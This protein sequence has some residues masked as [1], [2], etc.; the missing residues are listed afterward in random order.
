M[1]V[2]GLRILIRGRSLLGRLSRFRVDR[3]AL[4]W[5]ANRRLRDQS[6]E[7]RVLRPNT[8]IEGHKFLSR[9]FQHSDVTD[10][11]CYHMLDAIPRDAQDIA[12][13]GLCRRASPAF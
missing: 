1:A 8:S 5:T 3:S 7:P 9:G 2:I 13:L 11:H 12:F 4:L 10:R 6:G